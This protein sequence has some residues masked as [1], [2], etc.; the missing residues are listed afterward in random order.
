MLQPTPRL[1]E[2][3]KSRLRFLRDPYALTIAIHLRTGKADPSER[4][5]GGEGSEEAEEGPGSG[6]R[7]LLRHGVACAREIEADWVGTRHRVVWMIIS[8][9][10]PSVPEEARRLFGEVCCQRNVKM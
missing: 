2:S 7:E 9:G 1:M 6:W 10:H 8:D 5:E 4:G 3:I